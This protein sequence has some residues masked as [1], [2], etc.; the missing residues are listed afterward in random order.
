MVNFLWSTKNTIP[1]VQKTAHTVTLLVFILYLSILES[2]ALKR[3]TLF[4]IVVKSSPF[5][6][7]FMAIVNNSTPFCQSLHA[8]VRVVFLSL[9]PENQQCVKQ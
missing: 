2:Y 6:R 1:V 3:G 9:Q 8:P 7:G 5:P 4:F